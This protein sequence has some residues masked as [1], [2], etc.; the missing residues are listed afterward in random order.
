MVSSMTQ[1]DYSVYLLTSLRRDE[2]LGEEPERG[3]GKDRLI[4]GAQI[5]HKLIQ[6]SV[7]SYRR[8]FLANEITLN[9]STQNG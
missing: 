5:W 3:I 8:Y 9:K 7:S 2:I 6:E 4:V 1:I